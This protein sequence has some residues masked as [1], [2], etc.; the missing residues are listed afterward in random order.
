[1]ERFLVGMAIAAFFCGGA[2]SQSGPKAPVFEAADVHVRP[3][4]PYMSAR[5]DSQMSGGLLPGGRYELHTAAMA[6]LIRSAYGV[7][8]YALFGGPSWL[9]TDHFEIVAK[10]APGTAPADLKLMLQSL[11]AERFK[12][13]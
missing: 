11:L 3:P 6:D 5:G 13:V 2:L 1:M 10:T 4:D 12:L 9:E 7:D 8:Y